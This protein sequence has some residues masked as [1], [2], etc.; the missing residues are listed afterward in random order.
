MTSYSRPRV[1]NDNPYSEALFRTC[2]YRPDYP[3]EGFKNV[4]EARKWVMKFVDWYNNRHYHS[5][6]NFVT[7]NTR[8]NGTAEQIMEKRKKVYHTARNLHPERWAGEIRNWELEETVTLN[9]TDE[10]E[11]KLRYTG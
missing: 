6:L 4:D 1:S 8:H 5:G 10:A 2:K 7:P 3:Y 9:P 11:K